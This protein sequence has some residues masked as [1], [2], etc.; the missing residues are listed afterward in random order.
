MKT[1][2]R[3]KNNK[4]RKKTL[5]TVAAVLAGLLLIIL[6][7]LISKTFYTSMVFL[8][9]GKTSA[10]N[11]ASNFWSLF[12]SKHTLEIENQNLKSQIQS[13]GVA[14]SDRNALAKENGDLRASL[15][16]K[17]DTSHYIQA[18]V[19]SKPPFAPFDVITIEGGAKAGIKVGQRVMVGTT[20]IGTVT[21]AS[22]YTSQITLLSSPANKTDAFIGDNALPATLSGKGAG[23]FEVSLPQGS[24]VKEGDLVFATLGT[25]VLSIGK[26]ASISQNEASTLMTVLIAFP[27]SLYDLSYVQIISS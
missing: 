4:A 15:N 7:G 23:N 5:L 12:A 17:Q 25:D 18:R 1:T 21:S 19:L 16:L 8:S 24:E 3:S 20:Y 13:L 26:V 2:Y 27:F 9:F 22:D 6:T 11:T 14:L 10:T